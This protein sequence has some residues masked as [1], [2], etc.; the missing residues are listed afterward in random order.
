MAKTKS[1]EKGEKGKKKI[2]SVVKS[3]EIVTVKTQLEV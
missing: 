1:R 2:S 3:T